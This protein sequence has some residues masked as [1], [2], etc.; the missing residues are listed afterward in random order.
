M[1]DFA[2]DLCLI[3]VR[4]TL[5]SRSNWLKNVCIMIGIKN[6]A[7]LQTKDNTKKVW[8][9]TLLLFFITVIH[10]NGITY[11]RY[12]SNLLVLEKCLDVVKEERDDKKGVCAHAVQAREQMLLS[13]LIEWQMGWSKSSLAIP[14]L[15]YH[16][17][18][19][20]NHSE[21]KLLSSKKFLKQETFNWHCSLFKNDCL[22]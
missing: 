15:L 3:P 18:L 14:L 5:D 21:L 1:L 8:L 7:V 2:F 10:S 17:E 19:K 22:N 16:V 6:E 12:L 13:V 11:C 4:F 20:L 9:S